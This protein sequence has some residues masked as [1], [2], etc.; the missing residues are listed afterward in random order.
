MSSKRAGR[1]VRPIAILVL[2]AG[3]VAA[4]F[5][6][7]IAYEG[8]EG[9]AGPPVARWPQGSALEAPSDRSVVAVFLHP[10]CACSRATADALEKLATRLPKGW[11]GVAAF[12]R[13][14]GSDA[15][16]AETGLRERVARIP[17]FRVLDDVGGAEAERFGARTSGHVVAFDL[18]GVRLFAGGITGARGHVGDNAHLDSLVAALRDGAPAPRDAE[19]FGCPLAAAEA[20]GGDR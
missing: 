3:A 5:G 16:W 12:Y 11:R 10:R 15:D 20:N 7:L 17:G 13:P 8:R 6:A 2:W 14:E 18:L 4:G 9:E 19:V 1:L